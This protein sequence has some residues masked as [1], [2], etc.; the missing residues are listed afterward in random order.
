MSEHRLHG[1]SRREFLTRLGLAAG[2]APLYSAMT[3]LGLITLPTAYAGP[4]RLSGEGGRG[5]KVVIVGAG[6]AGL[7]SA[8]ELGKAGYDCTILEATDHI[9]GRNRTA[10]RGDTLV[11][12][13]SVQRCEFDDDPHLYMNCGPARLPYHHHGILGYCREL[14]VALEPFV[15]DNRGAWVHSSN[16]F[17]GQRVRAQRMITDSR[18]AI[19]ELLSKAVSR[20]ALDREFSKEDRQKLLAFMRSFGDLD[21]QFRYPGSTRAGFRDGDGMLEAG[22]PNEPYP[23]D[24][25]LQSDYWQ[26]KMEFAE[27]WDMAATMMQPVGGMDMIVRGFLQHIS[28]TVRTRAPVI[29]IHNLDHGVRV[30]YHDAQSGDRELLADFCINCAPAYLTA[31]IESNFSPRYVEALRAVEPGKLFK[32]GFQAKRRFWEEDDHIYGGISWTDQDVLQ[33]WYPS[34]GIHQKKGVILG[35]YTFGGPASDRFARLSPTA[36]LDLALA[37]GERL[38]PGYSKLMDCGLSVAWQNVPYLFGCAPEWTEEARAKHYPVL[39]RAEGRH[40]L[41]GDQMSYHSGWQ[42]GAVC[43]AHAAIEDIHQ[44]ASA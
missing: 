32:I 42:E 29:A 24:T 41:V 2:G 27:F 9:G 8:Y 36:R 43:S 34:H 38:H 16:A 10:R 1:G 15:N 25:L 4:P 37:Q 23:L 12:S 6:I 31:G 18:G 21:A 22:E 39:Q 33:I 14:G 35:A 40:Y 26:Y 5:K 44:R 3:A 11:E 7:V 17:G 28:A 20:D 30:R 19:A 13:N